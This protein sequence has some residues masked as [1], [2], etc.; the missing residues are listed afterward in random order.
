MLFR[1]V[2]NLQTPTHH[3]TFL[4]LTDFDQQYHMGV[5]FEAT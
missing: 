5:M 1:A 3:C 4:D 2:L